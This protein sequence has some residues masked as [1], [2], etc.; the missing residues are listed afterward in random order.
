MIP[1]IQSVK[2]DKWDFIQNFY[3]SK[4]TIK[5]VKNNPQNGRKHL[6][7]Y[8]ISHVSRIYKEVLQHHNKKT[9]NPNE[10]WAKDFN[11]S[12]DIQVA[13]S[14]RQDAQYQ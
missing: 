3:A 9:N 14:T 8:L 10:T 7:I 4:D 11:F 12:K 6:Q 13:Y 5:G 1:K 2:T